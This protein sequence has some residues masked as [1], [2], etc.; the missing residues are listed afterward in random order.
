MRSQTICK[1]LGLV[2]LLSMSMSASAVWK[3]NFLVGLEGAYG[4]RDGNLNIRVAEA[5]PAANSVGLSRNHS[6]NGFYWGLLAGYQ[7]RCHRALFGLEAKVAW[8]DFGNRKAFH[9]VDATGE[10]YVNHIEYERD[11]VWSLTGRAGFQMNPFVMPYV[12][13][14][15]ESGD[16]TV[17]F[18]A[19]NATFGNILALKGTRS[20]YRFVSGLGVEMPLMDKVSMRVEYNYVADGKGV[21]TT[22]V[23]PGSGEVVSAA[24]KAGQH[25]FMLD[26]VWN[27]DAVNV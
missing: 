5:P 15:V 7:L 1:V 14:G 26:F 10:N 24:I 8:Q 3:G 19:N 9:F 11:T 17:L 2:S 18:N 6:D 27:F 25:A 20:N 23:V 21:N 13:I 12:R 22:G 16:E 4:S